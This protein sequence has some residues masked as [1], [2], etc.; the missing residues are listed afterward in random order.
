MHDWRPY[1]DNLSNGA[2]L[3]DLTSRALSFWSEDESVFRFDAAM[4]GVVTTVL[5]TTDVNA[6]P[7]GSVPLTE[8]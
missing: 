5:V 1:F 8:R 3:V 2:I 7:F 6:E 4:V